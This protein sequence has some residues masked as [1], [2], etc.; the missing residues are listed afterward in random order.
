[1]IY[2]ALCEKDEEKVKQ[3]LKLHSVNAKDK[4]YSTLKNAGLI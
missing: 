3:F 1:M 4:V 2:D